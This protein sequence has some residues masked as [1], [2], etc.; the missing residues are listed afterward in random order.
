MFP[1]TVQE[2]GPQHRLHRLVAFGLLAVVIVVLPFILPE[3]QVSRVNRM[4]F[5]SVAILGLNLVLGFNGLLALGHSAFIGL[6]AFL[7]TW[8]V[9]DH[10]WD[11]W[12]TIPIS[13]GACFLFGALLALPALRIRGLYLA[14]ITIALATVFPS[15][16]KMDQFGI[17]EATGGANGRE[18]DEKVLPPSWAQSLGFNVDEPSRYRYFL[19]VAMTAVAFWAV[20]NLLKSRPGRAIV[21]IR[22]NET[23]AAVSGVDLVRWKLLNFAISAS[24]GGLAGVMWA[25]DRAFVAEQ[26]FGFLLAVELLVGL[27]IGGVATVPGA[28]V[29]AFV[30]V[31]VREFTKGLQ[32]P[33]GFITI[34][35]EGPLSQAIFGGILVI[36]TFFAPGGLVWMFRL[37]KSKLYRVV[38]T[39]PELSEPVIPLGVEGSELA[40][41]PGGG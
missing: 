12:M 17:A 38:P 27:V 34:D 16:A 1:I 3:F 13:M 19:I 2:G 14:L 39:P 22:D 9:Q 20:L 4:L 8:L 5:L 36:V 33:L 23:G 37:A 30:V 29:G 31:F 28:I 7:T 6:G 15:L 21:A 10:N 26:G 24:L 25:M 11:Y 18:I 35:G 40:G 32:I 41:A